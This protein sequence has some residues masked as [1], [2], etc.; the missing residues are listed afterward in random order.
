M[1]NQQSSFKGW[2]TLMHPS[3]HPFY[4]WITLLQGGI[5]NFGILFTL[6]KSEY[7]HPCGWIALLT[8]WIT[9]F[10]G[11]SSSVVASM[12]LMEHLSIHIS[13]KSFKFFFSLLSK[14]NVFHLKGEWDLKNTYFKKWWIGWMLV[15]Q[16]HLS[17]YLIKKR[18]FNQVWFCHWIFEQL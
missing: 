2:F 1:S 11:E 13:N 9:L 5:W 14:V 10:T 16:L 7:V 8:W 17:N 6:Q 4:E 12:K 3:T 15:R 18:I